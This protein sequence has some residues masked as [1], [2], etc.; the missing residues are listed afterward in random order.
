M[1]ADLTVEQ[2]PSWL[3]LP[4][5]LEADQAARDFHLRMTD[6]AGWRARQTARQLAADRLIFGT[7]VVTTDG[8]RLDPLHVEL[9]DGVRVIGPDGEPVR[10]G[11]VV[12]AEATD[13]GMTVTVQ[14]PPGTSV[15][16][17]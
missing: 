1:T 13:V 3:T 2:V 7:A 12:S 5:A 14:L 9:G 15:V 11:E 17:A 10:G 8:E 4:P 6:P 16:V